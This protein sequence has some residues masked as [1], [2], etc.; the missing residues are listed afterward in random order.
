MRGRR[1]D[2]DDSK[3]KSARGVNQNAVYFECEVCGH[4]FQ[5]DPNKDFQMCPQ[6]GEEEDT[7]RI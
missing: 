1:N 2:D 6:C 5:D 3:P 4:R 7:A